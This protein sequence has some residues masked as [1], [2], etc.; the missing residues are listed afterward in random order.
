MNASNRQAHE[1]MLGACIRKATEEIDRLAEDGRIDEA[2]L[3][4]AERN[5]YGICTQLLHTLDEDSAYAAQTDK[6][7]TAW[8]E[9]RALAADHDDF[10]RVAL[11]DVKLAAL[12]KVTAH[13]E[14]G[15]R[16]AH[17]DG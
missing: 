15:G 12:A 2:N 11:E 1:R 16:G 6:L 8:M 4:K 14:S 3:K 10:A 5:I 17:S 13:W 9:A 7:R